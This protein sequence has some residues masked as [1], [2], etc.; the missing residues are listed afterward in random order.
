EPNARRRFCRLMCE[1]PPRRPRKVA[2]ADSA[3]PQT[4]R[5]P[6]FATGRS[7][8][9]SRQSPSR[10]GPVSDPSNGHT[11]PPTGS[12]P[13]NHL[14][15]TWHPTRVPSARADSLSTLDNWRPERRAHSQKTATPRSLSPETSPPAHPRSLLAKSNRGNKK[16]QAVSNRP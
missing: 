3:Q 14:D 1:S 15:S 16:V 11:K 12:A 2:N 4:Y 5:L 8:S 7:F 6:F 13:S 9:V 10:P